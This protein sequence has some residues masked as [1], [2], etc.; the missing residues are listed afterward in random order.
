MTTRS[1]PARSDLPRPLALFLI[2]IVGLSAI[3]AA[4]EET[5]ETSGLRGEG[6][7]RVAKVLTPE[8]AAGKLEVPDVDASAELTPAQI[9]E[10]L[11]PFREYTK[12][13]SDFRRQLAVGAGSI[14]AGVW[15]RLQSA[16]W[17]FGSARL[18]VDAAPW[19]SGRYPRGWPAGSTW[20]NTD[21]V[22]LPGNRL[23][24]I[25]EKRVNKQGKLVAATRVEEVVRHE[26]GH[27]FDAA[28]GADDGYRS[29]S[30]SFLLAYRRDAASMEGEDRETL[31]YY[32][33]NLQAG[34]QETFAE[35]FAEI[36]GGGSSPERA[37]AFRRAFPLVFAAV[38]AAIKECD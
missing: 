17:K 29:S 20:E 33:Q 7:R 31:A 36:H 27:A 5:R 9:D 1:A 26:I 37:E 16:G 34:R 35:A 24:L 2:S 18:V 21:A 15:K 10:R 32:L 12:T 30:S 23:L 19:L 28:I 11:R 6:V 14:P 38:R 8:P 25:G 13:G 4:A 22:H 3:S